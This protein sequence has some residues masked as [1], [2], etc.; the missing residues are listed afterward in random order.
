ME[1]VNLRPAHKTHEN[2]PTKSFNSNLKMVSARPDTPNGTS[3]KR[4]DPSE[5]FGSRR[6]SDVPNLK[7]PSTSTSSAIVK[8]NEDGGVT[9]SFMPGSSKTEKDQS[10]G[11]GGQN[12]KK[13]KTGIEYLGAGLERGVER[14]EVPESERKGRTQKRKGMRSGSKNAFRGL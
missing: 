3:S 13:R 2:R 10:A 6:K 9:L 14:T 12:H 11:N 7:E 1:T 8:H 5:T 4:R